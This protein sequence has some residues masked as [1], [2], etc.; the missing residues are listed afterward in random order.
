MD[1][2]RLPRVDAI[3][4][5]IGDGDHALRVEAARQAIGEAR[6]A[7]LA[8]AALP[9]EAAIVAA[10]RAWI[11]ARSAPTLRKVINATGVVV[12]TNLGRAPLPAEAVAAALGY[13]NLEYDLERGER[14]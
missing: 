8:G 12:H 13:C 9:D 6:A 2:S 14:G 5:L 4:E 7:V 10:A 1:L 3:A 11:A